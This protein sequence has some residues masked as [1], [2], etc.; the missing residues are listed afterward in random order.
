MPPRRSPFAALTLLGVFAVVGCA[1]RPPHRYFQP[2]ADQIG[3]NLN[4]YG[5]AV[6]PRHGLIVVQGDDFAYGLARGRSRHVING[7]DEG[8]AAITISQTLRRALNG[9]KVENRGYPGDTVASSALRWANAPPANLTILSFSYGDEAAHTGLAEFRQAVSEMI[10]ADQA[11]GGAVFAVLPPPSADLLR[12]GTQ[13]AYRETF[14]AVA[15][16]HAVQVF[17]AFAAMQR[18]KIPGVKT[19]AQPAGVYQ[20]VAADMVL[21]IKVVNA[22]APQ[23]GQSGSGGSLTVRD[24]A[25]NPS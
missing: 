15:T 20:G 7:A 22:P 5:E 11:H 19:T 25:A 16:E 3:P 21:Y 1:G 4:S 14:R 13:G 9:V 2:T 12:N 6:V 10:Q 24:S 17:D 18:L 23:T 8:Q